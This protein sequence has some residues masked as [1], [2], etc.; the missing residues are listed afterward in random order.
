MCHCLRRT[1]SSVILASG[2]F[3]EIHVSV[4]NC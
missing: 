3:S 4:L 1:R 2:C